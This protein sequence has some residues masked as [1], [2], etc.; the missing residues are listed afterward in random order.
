MHAI[1]PAKLR[2]MRA[3]PSLASKCNACICKDLVAGDFFVEQFQSKEQLKVAVRPSVPWGFFKNNALLL[4]QIAITTLQGQLF[5][6]ITCFKLGN[7][8]I[9]NVEAATRQMAPGSLRIASGCDLCL[10]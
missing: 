8:E 6:L 4:S 10:H 7:L 1:L 9:K 5:F 3:I 2:E